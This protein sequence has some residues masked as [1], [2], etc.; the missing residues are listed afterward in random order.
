MTKSPRVTKYA[1]LLLAA[2]FLALPP[3]ALAGQAADRA[4]AGQ[5]EAIR[6]YIKQGWQTLTRS[7]KQLAGAAADPKSVARLTKFVGLT[8]EEGFDVTASTA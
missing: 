4:T 6:K 8:P 5:L 1:H 7:N 2:L 3:T